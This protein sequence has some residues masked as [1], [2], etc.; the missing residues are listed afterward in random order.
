MIPPFTDREKC[1]ID[2]LTELQALQ[3][4]MLEHAPV[5]MHLDVPFR[6]ITLTDWKLL[7]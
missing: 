3:R 6:L 1:L 7:F 2:P 5:V 4:Q